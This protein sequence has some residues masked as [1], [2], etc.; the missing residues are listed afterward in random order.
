MINIEEILSKM[1][2]KEKIGQLTQ[3]SFSSDKLDEIAE[4]ARNG[5]IGS[6][7]LAQSSLAGQDE[8]EKSA[9]EVIDYLQK[10]I[11]EDGNGIPIITGR[12]V[13][14][15]YDVI[16][17]IP[18]AMAAT[19]NPCLIE[20]GYRYV[21]KSAANDGVHWTFAPMIDMSRD[22]RWG[23]IIE[24]P[25]EDPYLGAAMAKA[26]VKGFQGDDLK[27]PGNIAACAK[28]FIGYG[29]SEGGRDYHRAEISEYTLRNHYLPAFKGA[30]NAGVCTVMSS[31]NEISGQMVS[32]SRQLLTELLKD[33]LGFDGFVISDWGAIQQ[34][35]AQRAAEDRKDCAKLCI[36]AGLDMDMV[37]NC[38]RDYLEELVSEGAVSEEQIDNS[39]RRVLRIKERI[40]LFDNPYTEKVEINK[41]EYMN[42]A[43]EI[44]EESMV[45]LKNDNNT[46]P[47]KKSGK[48]QIFGPLYDE[49]RAIIGS[50]APDLNL[51][52]TETIK[53]AFERCIP[54]AEEFA[55]GNLQSRDTLL[56]RTHFMDATILVLGDSEI[57][58]GEA[59]SLARLELKPEQ[60]ALVREARKCKKPLIGVFV[61]GRPLALENVIDYFDAAL[62]CWHGGTKTGEAIARILFGDTAP[63]GRLPVT[64]P[65]ITGQLPIYYNAPSTGHQCENYYDYNL[66]AGYEDCLS[67]PLYPFGYGL[68]YTEFEYGEI[69]AD[70]YE[71]TYDELKGG[72]SFKVSVTVKNIGKTAAKETAQCY[73]T[74]CVASAMRPMREL[75]GFNKK[76]I[77]SG[78]S[79]RFEFEIGFNELG[80]YNLDNKFDVEKG[81]FDI[82]VGKNCLCRDKITVEVK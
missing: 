48:Y 58:T 72:K 21:A 39:V 24:S 28:H 61:S 9:A 80:F 71:L 59:H 19:Y 46:L 1:T 5:E 17:P 40:G 16:Y 44:A 45:L 75:K 18:L 68:S 63:S 34:L 8:S 29:A 37:D 52:I 47:L 33:E 42:K 81:R 36:N 76:L 49:R 6:L 57:V 79:V 62:F 77:N 20:D 64:F 60:E 74:D 15:G 27:T 14:H 38:Y 25:G 32:S 11:M 31:F 65:R 51:D 41:A 43:L 10:I 30:I 7:I 70:K 82:Y 22:A 53:E 13:I 23:R 35:I 4:M 26:V 78:E 67:S 69:S 50:W 66:T 3:I 12:D 2:L 55:W 56:W 73:V 54:E